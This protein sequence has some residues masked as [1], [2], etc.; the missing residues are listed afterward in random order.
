MKYVHIAGTNGKGSAAE[1]IYQII[2][3]AGETCGLFTSPH[4]VSPAERFRAN[5]QQIGAA[6]LDALLR[7]AEQKKLAVNGSLFA[8]YTAAALL[9]FERMGLDYAAL[10]T[11]LGGR[12]DPTNVV[13]P[14][15]S[16]LTAIGYDHMGLLGDTI[17]EIASEKAGIIKPG[18]PVVSARQLPEAEL[19]IRKTCGQKGCALF[20]ADDVKVLDAALTGQ[21]FESY[22]RQYHIRG[23]GEMQPE[24]AALAALAAREMGF[25]EEAIREGLARA[26]LPCRTQYIPDIPDM[27]LDGAH[28]GPAVAALCRTLD[29]CF[30]DRKKVLLFAC[31]QDKDYVDMAAQLA[32]RFGRAIVTSVDAVRGASTAELAALFDQHSPCTIVDDPRQAYET[33]AKAA[34]DTDALLVVCGSFYLTGMVLHMAGEAAQ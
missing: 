34:R 31:M 23:I 17:K 19:V 9:W 2:L 8:L 28:N 7:E 6:E 11:G 30:S 26:V 27:L 15:M 10:E 14:E 12:L 32:P 13:T 18:V 25:D 21:T 1:Y 4:L 20:F 29:R 33:A 5:G 24:A 22:G 16:V 3:A